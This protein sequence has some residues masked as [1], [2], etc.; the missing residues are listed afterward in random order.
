MDK[1][2]IVDDGKKLVITKM[3]NDDI[4]WAL[5]R[6]VDIIGPFSSQK[7]SDKWAKENMR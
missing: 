3:T 1:W 4:E 7:E 6:G 5:R 2:Y